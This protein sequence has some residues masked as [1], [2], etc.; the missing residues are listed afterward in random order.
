MR[1]TVILRL[2]VPLLAAC[3]KEQQARLAQMASQGGAVSAAGGNDP[4]TLVSRAEAEGLLGPLRHD[5]FRVNSGGNRVP[6]P[7][8]G[9][10]F[11]EAANGRRVIMDVDWKDGQMGMR[12]VGM[13][14]R[15]AEQVITTDTGQAD[16]LE[17][18]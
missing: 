18:R 16:T 4:C 8:G 1:T 5:P 3:S 14:G 10:C 13:G 7:N 17:G 12:V 6:E 9:A 11:Y 15:L 2:L